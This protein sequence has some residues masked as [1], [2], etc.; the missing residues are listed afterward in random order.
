MNRT[1]FRMAFRTL[2]FLN[3]QASSPAGVLELR[4]RPTRRLLVWH[5]EAI[6]QIFRTDQHLHHP[7]SR[8]LVPLLGRES[9]LWTE[10]PRHLAYRRLL[11]QP[12]RGRRLGDFHGVIADAAAAAVDALTPGTVI[13]LADW[14]RRLTLRIIARIVL[15][16]SD[17]DVLGPFI[18]WID[19]ALGSRHRT[20]VYRYL[21]GGLP[22]SGVDL[23]RLLVGGAKATV[24]AK[25]P[26]LA[27]LMLA[28][29]GLL[30]DIGDAE[31]RD[32]IVSLLFAG[33][34]TTASATAWALFLLD[35]DE[36]LRR[37][38]LSELDATG[39]D[40]SDATKVPLLH[41]VIQETL[42]IAPPVA[43]AGNRAFTQ[44]GEL[45]GRPLAAGTV[46]TPSIYLAH[47]R[48]DYFPEPHRFRPSRF[49]GQRVPAQHYFPFGGGSRHCLG[50]QLGQVE[51][52]MITAAVLRHRELRCVNPWA[53]V[54]QLRGHAMAPSA[55]L[56]MEVTA[57]RR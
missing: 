53:G 5:P 42:R 11:G 10:G 27:A 30:H 47:H 52:R 16:R 4:D 17:D 55:R 56:R 31:L 13:P 20:L 22:E 29:T 7:P 38:V 12:L 26:A 49:L 9:L 34:E 24:T 44:D 18:A 2:P 33:H 57:C 39:D 28:D 46:L 23:D 6:D 1:E 15:G 8:T 36:Q 21:R 41:A 51:I 32:Q 50:N 45:L 35:R 54:P 43:V 48:P 14:T 40:G 19:H 37:D 25:P 3:A